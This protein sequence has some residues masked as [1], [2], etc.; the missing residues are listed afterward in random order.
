MNYFVFVVC[1]SKEHTEKL[2]LSLKFLQHFSKHKILVV[3]DSSRNEGHID[4]DN[5]IDVKTPEGLTNHESSIYLKT[6]LTHFIKEMNNNTYCYLDSDVVAIS[7]KVDGVF[8]YKP[9]PVLFAKDHCSFKEFSPHAMKCACLDKTIKRNATFYNAVNACFPYNVFS[10]NTQ[11]HHE[12]SKLDMAFDEMKKWHPASFLKAIKYLAYRYIL[13]VKKVYL[14]DYT[15]NKS[16]KCWY[17]KLGKI[18]HFDYRYYSKQLKKFS[19]IRYDKKQNIWKDKK[20]NNI[21]PETP[22]CHH[23]S[24]YIERKYNVKISDNWNHWNGGVFLF[25]KNAKEFL[26]YWHQISLEEFKSNETKTRD[27]FTLAVSAWKFGLQH[28]QTLPYVFNFIPEYTNSDLFW[29]TSKNNS[30]NG[31]NSALKPYFVHVYHHWGDSNWKTWQYIINL[32]KK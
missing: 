7:P 24:E 12:K 1:G 13:P 4:H 18:I 27:Q 9:S 29:N 19:G 14:S 5:I 2:N 21:T 16:N 6:G 32:A 10:S 20:G 11:K 31:L 26:D 23:L 28:Q 8:D 15:F 3:T 17:D 30:G 22:H 25:N